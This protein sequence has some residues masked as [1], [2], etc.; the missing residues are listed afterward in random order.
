MGLIRLYDLTN[1]NIRIFVQNQIAKRKRTRSKKTLV[2]MTRAM[3]RIRTM[4]RK[5]TMRNLWLPLRP[6]PLVDGLSAD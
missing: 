2:K 1:S 4:M 3:M 5:M 6:E